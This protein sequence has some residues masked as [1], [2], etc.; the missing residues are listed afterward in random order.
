MVNVGKREDGLLDA[1][2]AYRTN[3]DNC[4]SVIDFYLESHMIAPEVASHLWAVL[5]GLEVPDGNAVPGN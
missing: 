4:K 1:L 5:T 2:S 3:R